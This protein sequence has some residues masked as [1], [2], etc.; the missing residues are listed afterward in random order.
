MA[1]AFG[2]Y[3][4]HFEPQNPKVMNAKKKW[5]ATTSLPFLAEKMLD[6]IVLVF[7][8]TSD[9]HSHFSWEIIN[10]CHGLDLKRIL[11]PVKHIKISSEIHATDCF[12]R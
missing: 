3:R 4:R 1:G 10:V 12:H 8:W 2:N 11:L 6:T 7:G 5:L 9:K